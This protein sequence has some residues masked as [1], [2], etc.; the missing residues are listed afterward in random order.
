LSGLIGESPNRSAVGLDFLPTYDLSQPPI[1][2]FDEDLGQNGSNKGQW[3]C[4]VKH[5]YI[6][7]ALESGKELAAFYLGQNWSLWPFQL[8][9]RPVAVD[10]DDQ[11]ITQAAGLLQ[12][13]NVPWMQK[14][15]ASIGEYNSLPGFFQFSNSSD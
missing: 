5:S 13:A 2:T 6:A 1:T 3:R 7:D 12:I 9:H 8:S 4:F 10:S 14:I 11:D 15:K